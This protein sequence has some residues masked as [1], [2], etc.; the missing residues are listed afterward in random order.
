[1]GKKLYYEDAYLKKWSTTIDTVIEK[2]GDFLVT[3][4]ETAFYP[5]GGGQ[6]SDSGTIGGIAVLDVFSENDTVFHKLPGRPEAGVIECE[7]DWKRRFDHMQ[8]HSGQHLL[9]AV[10]RELYDANTI[11]FHL[12]SDTVSIDIEIAGLSRDQVSEIESQANQYIFD[13]RKIHSYFVTS[14]ELSRLAVVKMP[15]VTENIRIVETEGIEYNPCGG[16]HVSA[17]GSIGSIKIVKTE[18]QKG[19]TRI[20]FKCGFRALAHFN[21]SLDIL[22]AVSSKFNTGHSDIISRIDK[23]EQDYRQVLAEKEKL[24]EENAS[25]LIR[26][27]IQDS[28]GGIISYV[29]EDKSLKEL[30]RL[31]A[32]ASKEQDVLLL[33]GTL[34]DKKILFSHSGAAQVHCGSFLKAHLHSFNG[35]GG[36]NDKSAQAGFAAKEDMLAFFEFVKR[37]LS[38]N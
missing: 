20:F 10:C 28:G 34:K 11:S 29:F 2:D 38:E 23:L 7:I 15:K 26:D 13:N 31:A 6:P 32:I 16:T 8:Q 17:T 24:A 3:L 37:E 5:E 27:L 12:G 4:T 25:Y 14:D 33:F 21:D 9:S 36:G 19:V 22:N 30:Q 35:K 18:K 1:M